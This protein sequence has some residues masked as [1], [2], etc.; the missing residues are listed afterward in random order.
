MPRES[1]LGLLANRCRGMGLLG[2]SIQGDTIKKMQ[3]AA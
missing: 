3:C 1:L 2:G